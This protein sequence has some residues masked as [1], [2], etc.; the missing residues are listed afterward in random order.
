[1]RIIFLF[2]KAAKVDSIPAY[3]LQ[4]QLVLSNLIP[5][6]FHLVEKLL[7]VVGVDK[8]ILSIIPLM[9]V[10]FYQELNSSWKT[11]EFD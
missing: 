3:E 9:S 5:V 7:N 1:M 11:P 2:Y 8:T 4:K 6:F 10:E